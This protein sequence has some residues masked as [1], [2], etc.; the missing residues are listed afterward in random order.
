MIIYPPLVA[1]MLSSS[2]MIGGLKKSPRLQSFVSD[3]FLFIPLLG[4]SNRILDVVADVG[5]P[6]ITCQFL[7]GLVTSATCSI[8]YGT[9]PTYV[10]LPYTDSSNGTNVNN[11]TVPLST[12]LQ[13]DTLYYYVVSSIGLQMQGT[14][15]TGKC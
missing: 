14:F 2:G 10:N 11:V 13:G 15:R 5:V 1:N 7:S 8:Q 6:E 3:P 4:S 9:D 12:A